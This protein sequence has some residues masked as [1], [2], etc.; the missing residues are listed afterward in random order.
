MNAIIPIPHC[1][2]NIR[3]ATM[4]DYAF[5]D[6]LQ[7]ASSKNVGFLR[8]KALQ[9][10][11]AAGHVLVAWADCSPQV[12]PCLSEDEDT[13]G[14]PMPLPL[15]YCIGNDKYMKRED[16]GIIYQL[17]VAPGARR[18]LIGAT[19]IQALFERSAYGCRLFCCWCAQ[20]IEANH[21]WEALGFIP[22]AFRAGSRGKQR[23][24]IFWQRR[25]R[26]GDCV[27]PWWFPSQTSAG[28]IGEDRLVLPIPPGVKWSD[29]MPVILPTTP[30]EPRLLTAGPLPAPKTRRAKV[31]EKTLQ[32]CHGLRLADPPKA[33]KAKQKRQKVKNDPAHVAAARELRD[34]YLEQFNAGTILLTAGLPGGKYDVSRA[35]EAKPSQVKMIA[36]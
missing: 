14:S 1:E 15:G 21:F 24:H 7:K 20:D 27:T 12:R 6:G 25:I 32:T 3:P 19:L 34:R 2:V 33:A 13:G 18:K 22:L 31:V 23:V 17:N 26:E 16:V 29:E 10:K 28:S 5:I 9:G 11:I 8:A 4:S 30:R 35:I 36:A